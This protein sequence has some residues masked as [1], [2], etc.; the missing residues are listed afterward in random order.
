[1]VKVTAELDGTVTELSGSEPDYS[2]T[3]TAPVSKAAE[4]TTAYALT[5]TATGDNGGVSEE[6]RILLVENASFFPLEFIAAKATGEEI[7][8]VREEIDLDID[9]GDTNEFELRLNMEDWSREKFWYDNRIFAAQT[10]Y[11]GLIKKIQ[12]L[13]KTNEVVLSDRETLW[14]P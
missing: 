9:L 3:M 11:G 6:T 12:V 8:F 5:V 13:T 10:E 1:M 4:G 7:N 2:G 14:T